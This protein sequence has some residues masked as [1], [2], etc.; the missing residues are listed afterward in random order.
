MDMAMK[1]DSIM[2]TILLPSIEFI[3]TYN[4]K[5]YEIKLQNIMYG[6]IL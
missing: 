5:N 3:T 2:W 4:S 1:S 6:V